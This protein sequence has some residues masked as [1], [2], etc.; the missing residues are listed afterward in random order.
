MNPLRTEANTSEAAQSGI[1]SVPTKTRG[2]PAEA[3]IFDAP[4]LALSDASG[5]TWR[6]AGDA[7]PGCSRAASAAQHIVVPGR[8]VPGQRHMGARSVGCLTSDLE[9]RL[10]QRIE[11]SGRWL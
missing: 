2:A 6:S 4:S 9:S 8:G 1:A 5:E 7:P 10:S 3:S 11:Q